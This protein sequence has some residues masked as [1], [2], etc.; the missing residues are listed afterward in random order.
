M[1]RADL[2]K[3]RKE[4]NYTKEDSLTHDILGYSLS[5]FGAIVG[6]MGM[7]SSNL[8]NA[9]IGIGIMAAGV[10]ILRN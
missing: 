5:I 4:R 1:T 6:I 3:K 10:Y 8:T 7:Y 9:F 2:I